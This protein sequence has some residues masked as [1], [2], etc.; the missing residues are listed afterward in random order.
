L[1]EVLEVVVGVEWEGE[2]AGVGG[3]EVCD[4]G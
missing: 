4:G 1:V 2:K 3:E